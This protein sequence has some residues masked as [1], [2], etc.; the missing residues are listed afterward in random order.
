MAEEIRT[1]II[2][3]SS[4]FRA[5][6]LREHFGDRFRNFVLLPPDIDEKAYRAADPFEL[7]ESIARA[8]MKAVL[9]KARQHSP[10]ISG[11]A[12][13]LTFDQVVVKGDEV[14][15][16]PLSTEQCRS[17]IASYSGGGVRTVATYALCVVGTENVLVAHNET[18]TFFSKFGDDIVE[19]TLERGACMNSAGGLVVEDEDMSRHVVRIVGTSYGVRGM[20]PAVVEKLLSQL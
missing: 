7:T 18:E 11:P 6:V 15:E 9:E 10:P 4:A 8:K 16:K 19:R 12:I 13:A 1:M 17:F 5:N 3:T 2:G 20:E 14:R